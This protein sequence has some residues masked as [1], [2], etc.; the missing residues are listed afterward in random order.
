MGFNAYGELGNGTFNTTNLP[1]QIVSSNVVAIAGGDFHSLFLKSDGSLW[2]MGYN[3]FGGLGDGTFNTTNLPEQIVPSNVVAIACGGYHSLFAKSDGS[4]WAM[5]YNGDGELGDGTFN[6]TN[7][8][9]RIVSSGVVAIAAGERHSLF[10]KSDGSVWGMGADD[11][12][13]LGDGF[14]SNSSLT[15]Q[16][17]PLPQP[18][19]K[20][21]I[22]SKSNLQFTATCQ[23]VGTFYLLT[24]TNI[25]RS[26]SQWTSVW[27]N[28][29][30]T[31]GNDNFY[32]ALSNAMSPSVRQQFYILQL[33]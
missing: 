25:T 13:A 9:E 5:G 4:L 27:T 24:S 10:L 2:V 1:E 19:L 17:S 6:N 11:D 28:S 8:P 7:R 18:V 22:S 26:L 31:R 23:F 3:Y 12:G 21:V 14:N 29:I 33:H 15:E 32:A 30:D 20:S 16:I